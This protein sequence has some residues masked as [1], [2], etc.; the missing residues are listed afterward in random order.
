MSDDTKDK[1]K[2]RSYASLSAYERGEALALADEAMLRLVLPR[3]ITALLRQQYSMSQNAAKRLLAEAEAAVDEAM[4]TGIARRRQG[5]IRSLARLYERA[6][7]DGK[8]AV[9][10]GV[11]KAI[12]DVEGYNRA[13]KVDVSDA[14]SDA[15][16]ESDWDRDAAG[17]PP[18]EIQYYLAHGCWPEESPTPTNG[19]GAATEAPGF[20]FPLT[21]H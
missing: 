7:L 20:V 1:L 21:R 13:I 12:A 8:L 9:G 6:W 4:S 10:L 11:L 5:H 17:R 14:R 18:A 3:R 16:I 19:A 15:D 2:S